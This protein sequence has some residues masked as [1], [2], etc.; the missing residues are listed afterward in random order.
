MSR[1]IEARDGG[2][3]SVMMDCPGNRGGRGSGWQRKGRCFSEENI[4][5]YQIY[6]HNLRCRQFTK[7]HWVSESAT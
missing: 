5:F 4:T 7:E 3:L 1:K 6:L 2:V